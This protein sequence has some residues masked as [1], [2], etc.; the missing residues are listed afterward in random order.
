[1][2]SIKR[3]GYFLEEELLN[4]ETRNNIVGLEEVREP[5]TTADEVGS[6]DQQVVVAN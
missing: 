4:R 3:K 1:M 6:S 2:I 5:Q